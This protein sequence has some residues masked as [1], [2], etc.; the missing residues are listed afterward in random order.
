LAELSALLPGT[1]L[2]VKSKRA[3]PFGVHKGILHVFRFGRCPQE[4]GFGDVFAVQLE[5]LARLTAL[6]RLSDEE[7]MDYVETHGTGASTVALGREALLHAVVPHKCVIHV[8]P[9][10]VLALA[11]TLGGSQ[12][13]REVY[14]DLA[15]VLPY[16][17]VGLPLAKLCEDALSGRQDKA[18]GLVLM[19]QG[20]LGFGSTMKD[21]Y[22]GM[23]EL[24]DRAEAYLVRVEVEA[25]R[26]P[27]CTPDRTMRDELPALRQA[28][29][30]QCSYPVILSTR[31]DAAWRA[32]AQ[33]EDL[34]AISR[35]GP[36]P[37]D[38]VGIEWR[39]LRRED[40]GA[41][42]G[43]SEANQERSRAESFFS[44]GIVVSSAWGLGAFARTATEAQAVADV[45]THARDIILRAEALGAYQ[46]LSSSG[47]G[48]AKGSAMGKE[49]LG[50]EDGQGMFAGEIAL[51][52]GAA[53]GIGRGCVNAFLARGAAVV[54]LDI[55]PS[56]TEMIDRADFLGLLC[57]VTDSEAI[58]E[59]LRIT[60]ERFGGLDMLVPNAGMF[61]PGCRIDALSRDE[62][63]RVMEVNLDA[64]L[65]LMREAHPLLKASP[66]GGRVVVMG[67]RNVPAPGPGA[68]A[69]SVS[70][71]GL[72]QMA[73]VAALEWGEDG[74]RVNIIN[75]HA[76]FDT[77]IWT[78]EVLQA[79]ADHYG[80]TVEEYKT[81]N[82]LG[83]EVTSRDVGELVAEMCGPLFDK[84]TGAQIPID[85]GSER[86]V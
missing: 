39:F 78:D 23:L 27:A 12:R 67:S 17:E 84:A 30:D 26:T 50:A 64:N 58:S 37:A 59:A 4:T 22:E 60:V 24:V 14:G 31:S 52:T 79:R 36:I 32:F 21:A 7:L 29:S 56:I 44:P 15:A 42:A 63:D 81:R 82:V 46:P 43:A 6:D 70:K 49:Q 11:N 19:Q 2:S 3:D 9:D 35:Q 40:L 76:V 73:R 68:V 47:P 61:P 72:V 69:Y 28:I 71:A 85:G 13:L 10:A 33:R 48:E 80:L 55:D 20:V 65:A 18:G 16:A 74:I 75:P 8:Y 86:V 1:G 41:N 38:A 5:P 66:R 57:D 51:I 25:G 54:G 34:Y 62:W 45:Y 83:V 77:G 53:S